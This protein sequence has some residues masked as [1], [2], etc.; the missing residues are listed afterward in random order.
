[1]SFR[2][3]TQHVAFRRPVSTRAVAHETETRFRSFIPIITSQ[4]VANFNVL[5]IDPRGG[6]LAQAKGRTNSIA[7][8]NHEKPLP[9]YHSSDDDVPFVPEGTLHVSFAKGQS[10][11][12]MAAFAKARN[13]RFLGGPQ[14]GFY[15][16]DV[17]HHRD[18]DAVEIAKS[19]QESEFIATAEPDLCTPASFLM[20]LP[21]DPLFANQWHLRNTGVHNDIAT[22]SLKQGADARVIDA[23]ERMG[24]MG[25]PDVVLS[26][27]DDGFDLQHPDLSGISVHAHDFVRDSDDVRPEPDRNDAT[28]GDWHGTACAGLAVARAGTGKT[29]GVAPNAKFMPLRMAR[30]LSPADVANWFDYAT[31]KGAWVIS[32]SWNAKAKIYP[33]PERIHQALSRAATQGRGGK[34]TV[35]VFA[36]GNSGQDINDAPNS[37]NG[38]AIHPDVLAVAASTS[39]DTRASYSDTGAEIAVCAPSGGRGGMGVTTDDASGTYIDAGGDTVSMGYIDG[40]YNSSFSGTSAACPVVAGV[41]ALVLGANPNLTASETRAIIRQSARA[42]GDPSDYV[43]G[44]SR[45][46]GHGCVDADAAVAMAQSIGQEP[47][48]LSELHTRTGFGDLAVLNVTPPQSKQRT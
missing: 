45:Q 46:Y 22:F 4:Q 37:L 40:S 30:H 29:V 39:V 8:A 44:H 2:K 20:Q 23:W 1:M 34:G 3:S 16:L 33:L 31:E 19:L 13:L 15:T 42:I 25:N 11:A 47:A 41:C 17:R 14:D 28:A 18:G 43:N 5:Q 48:L 21:S 32:A 9:V 27:I 24:H 38:Y 6:D 36:A 7:S 26:M 10:G 35:L 12:D